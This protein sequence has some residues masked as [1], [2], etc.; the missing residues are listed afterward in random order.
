MPPIE[1]KTFETGLHGR[2]RADFGTARTLRRTVR[3]WL[4]EGGGGQKAPLQGPFC[5][6]TVVNYDV[7]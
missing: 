2:N 6:L 1:L 5:A 7:T 4:F 3:P